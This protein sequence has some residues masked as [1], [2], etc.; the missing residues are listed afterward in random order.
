[1]TFV[2]AILSPHRH[3]LVRLDAATTDLHSSVSIK[4][5]QTSLVT[6]EARGNV[7]EVQ[8]M[9]R[10]VRGMIGEVRGGQR[11]AATSGQGRSGGSGRSGAALLLDSSLTTDIAVCHT[12]DSSPSHRP[13]L[14][15]PALE[16]SSTHRFLHRPPTIADDHMSELALES[17]SRASAIGQLLSTH[18][19]IHPSL[20]FAFHSH[21]ED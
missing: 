20:D 16:S 5:A 13:R 11:P 10:E 6:S 9:V 1:V 2:V 15:R 3:R 17:R 12:L 14:P 4:L 8:D 7:R 19:R 18:P 21:P